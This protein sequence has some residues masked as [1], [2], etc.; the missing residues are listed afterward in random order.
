MILAREMC[1]ETKTNDLRGTIYVRKWKHMYALWNSGIVNLNHHYSHAWVPGRSLRNDSSETDWLWV[2]KYTC[3]CEFRHCGATLM[4]NRNV[5]YRWTITKERYLSPTITDLV[6]Y[7]KYL[8]SLF[9]DYRLFQANV[10][11]SPQYRTNFQATS[12]C[13]LENAWIRYLVCFVNTCTHL[14]PYWELAMPRRRLKR[15][16]PFPRNF[17]DRFLAH[18]GRIDTFSILTPLTSGFQSL[19]IQ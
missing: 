10:E 17:A 13:Q 14:E 8:A 9:E 3:L 1:V 16:N 4:G 6:K 7:Q 12:I 5:L 15:S 11:M 18:E 2:T 19:E